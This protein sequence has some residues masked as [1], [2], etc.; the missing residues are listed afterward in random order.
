MTVAVCVIFSA[1]LLGYPSDASALARR[2][3]TFPVELGVDFGPA[4]KPAHHSTLEI[5]K[6][7]TPKDI[8]S[9]VFPI[10]TGKACC[11]MREIISIDAVAIDPAKNRW[12]VCEVNG[13]RS[14]SPS[15]R[16]LKRGE[17]VEWKYVE[18]SQ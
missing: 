2:P 18:E 5:D 9:Q 12:W 10:M 13:S 4:G 17:I 11:S 14:I 6:G 16:K 1:F 15:K 7:M 8:V 3:K